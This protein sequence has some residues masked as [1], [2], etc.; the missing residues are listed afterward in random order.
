MIISNGAYPAPHDLPSAQT[1]LTQ[2]SQSFKQVGFEVKGLLNASTPSLRA[3]LRLF[4]LGLKDAPAGSIGLVYFSGHGLQ[5]GA[6]NLLLGVDIHPGA[7]PQE[8]LKQAFEV[9]QDWLEWMPVREDCLQVAVIDACRTDLSGLLESANTG[10]SQLAA[11][12]GSIVS[13]STQAGRPAIAP[14]NPDQLTFYAQALTDQVQ[15]AS[16]FSDL[17]E[18]L[19]LV[20]R[21]VFKSMSS[22]PL[23]LIRQLAQDP[24]LADNSRSRLKLDPQLKSVSINPEES[25]LWTT[26][27]LANWP[28]HVLG[29]IERFVNTFPD[30]HRVPLARVYEE[31][32]RQAFDALKDPKIR[33]YRTS[34]Q[35]PDHAS[36][37]AQKDLARAA[38]GDKDAAARLAGLYRSLDDKQSKLRYEGWLQLASRLGNG[39][40]AYELALLYRRLNLPQPAASA[41]ARA[42]SLGYTP[43]PGLGHER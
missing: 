42:V 38:R 1:N 39:L 28:P 36:N 3:E 37:E 9:Q 41:E 25:D 7:P 40:A 31:G 8:L 30:S 17:G 6:K 43:P 10:L 13:F 11:P 33:L 12:R 19:R 24:F 15:E 18:L 26:I 27:E 22:H 34:F 35:L 23:K 14:A 16:S 4:Y 32:A 21:R 2:L 5:H 29:L 20:K